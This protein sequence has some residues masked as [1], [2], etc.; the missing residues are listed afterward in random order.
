MAVSEKLEGYPARKE[1]SGAI[2][3]DYKTKATMSVLYIKTP[4]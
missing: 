1:G 3:F 2:K 4:E